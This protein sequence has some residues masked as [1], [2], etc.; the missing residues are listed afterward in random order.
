MYNG[1]LFL[2]I[3][4]PFFLIRISRGLLI[5]SIFLK[6][7]ILVLWFSFTDWFLKAVIMDKIKDHCN[8]FLKPVSFEKKILWFSTLPPSAPG[9]RPLMD[10]SESQCQGSFIGTSYSNGCVWKVWHLASIWTSRSTN[11]SILGQKPVLSSVSPSTYWGL[12]ASNNKWDDT[13][14]GQGRVSNST[15]VNGW[16]CHS[17]WDKVN[18]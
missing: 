13:C 12:I 5:L 17:H 8:P 16:Y 11:W 4:F 6:N 1:S 18:I 3:L 2:H 14:N 15:H 9:G 10:S 7:Q